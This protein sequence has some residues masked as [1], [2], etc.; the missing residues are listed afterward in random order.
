MSAYRQYIMQ[1]FYISIY[2]LHKFGAQLRSLARKKIYENQM[3]QVT[4]TCKYRYVNI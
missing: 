4:D 2:I 1:P 3:V